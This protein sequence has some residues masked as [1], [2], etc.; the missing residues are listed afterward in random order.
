MRIKNLRRI[1]TIAAVLAIVGLSSSCNRGYG[2]PSNFSMNE[3][4]T[5]VVTWVFNYLR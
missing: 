1:C 2:C 5:D 4:A 3:V